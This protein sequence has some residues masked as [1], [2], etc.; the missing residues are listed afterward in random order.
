MK[1]NHCEC[2]F[3]ADYGL[4]ARY[5]Y[6]PM[7]GEIP[8]PTRPDP[9]LAEL[10]EVERIVTRLLTSANVSKEPEFVFCLNKANLELYKAMDLLRR[11]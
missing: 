3:W 8:E 9:R 6:N 5:Y 11:P 2:K 4:P 1:C 10:R 7:S